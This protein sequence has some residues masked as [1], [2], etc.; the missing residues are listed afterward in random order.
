MIFASSPPLFVGVTGR[1]L[2]VLFRRPMVFEV[3]DVWPAA[4]VSA[5][6]IRANGKAFRIGRSLEKYLYKRA[7]H[8]TCVAA[9]MRDYLIQQSATPVTVVYN[10]ISAESI[11]AEPT[12]PHASQHPNSPH[13]LLYA[14][15]LGHVQQL[16]LLLQAI[17]DLQQQPDLADWQVQLLGAGAQIFNL[18]RLAEKLQLGDRVRF[19]R[20]GHT[21]RG[22]AANE[23]G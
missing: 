23:P 20:A 9:P 5:G 12:T 17:A 3:R 8:I 11:E 19:L 4:A 16:D 1:A 13:V 7:D 10:G 15:N 14:G 22:R 2:S 21:G 18:K 6:Q